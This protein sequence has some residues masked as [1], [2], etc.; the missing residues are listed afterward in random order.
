MG[1]GCG[2]GGRGNVWVLPGSAVDVDYPE[3]TDVVVGGGAGEADVEGVEGGVGG[4]WDVGF[5]L[6]PF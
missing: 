1:L 5:E 3:T 2:E 4:V 6:R